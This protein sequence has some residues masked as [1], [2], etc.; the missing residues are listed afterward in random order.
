[1]YEV[2]LNFKNLLFHYVFEIMFS[3]IT[4]IFLYFLNDLNTRLLEHSNLK[5]PFELMMYNDGEPVT[6]FTIAFILFI[7]GI[8]ITVFRF[9]KFF[10]Y[11]DEPVLVFINVILIFIIVTLLVLLVVFINNPILRAIMS[12]VAIVIGAGYTMS[13]E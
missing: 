12:I 9:K 4:I 10:H 13:K 1:M 3:I 8:F 11:A 7:C 2:K 6:Y 5:N